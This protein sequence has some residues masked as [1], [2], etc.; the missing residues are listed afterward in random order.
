MIAAI[1]A[2]TTR[3]HRDRAAVP[4][5]IDKHPWNGHCSARAMRSRS[6]VVLV[7]SL[8]AALSGC[9]GSSDPSADDGNANQGGAGKGGSA[10]GASGSSA[11]GTHGAGAGGASPTGGA[12]HGGSAGLGGSTGGTSSGGTSAAGAAGTGSAGKGGSGGNAAGKGGSAGG[13]PGGSGGSSG[14]AAGGPMGGSGGSG[15]AA[16]KTVSLGYYTG[17]ASSYASLTSFAAYVSMIASDVFVVKADGSFDG[18][19]SLGGNTFANGHQIAPYACLSNY[20]DT[21]GDFDPKLGHAALVTSKK[22]TI[23]NAVALAKNGYAGINV[24]FESVYSGGNVAD[25]RAAYSSFIHDLGAAL[26]AE[27]KKLVISVPAKTADNAGD[28]WSYPYDYAALGADVDFIQMMTYDENGPGWSAPGPVSGADWV[29]SCIQWAITVAPKTKL[30][31]GLPAYGYDWD[32][33]ASK[34]G[35]WVGTSVAWTEVAPILATAGATT[36]WDMKSSTPY[37]D[38]K[39]GDGHVHQLWY[40][41]PQSITTKTKLVPKYGIAGYSTWALGLED[42]SFW[43]AAA[44]GAPL[45]FA[46]PN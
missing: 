42:L 27:G 19:D 34:Q 44:A 35:A 6:S 7:L 20:N 1:T 9:G 40:E 37:V 32:T 36:H 43:Q 8:M 10:A 30:L 14:G 15:G 45:G 16:A 26:H 13:A 21:L 41:T 29:E 12:G 23:A 31:I 5:N 46:S 38:Y 24:D 33:T 11:G 18:G 22:A 4:E 28:T 2:R 39:T 3:D 17:T 25:D